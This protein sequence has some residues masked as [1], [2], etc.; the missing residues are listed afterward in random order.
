MASV[1]DNPYELAPVTSSGHKSGEGVAA[2]TADDRTKVESWG[3]AHLDEAE[4]R[5]LALI[6]RKC[7]VIRLVIV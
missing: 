1:W 4:V 3:N 2:Q 7:H 6:L 5:W